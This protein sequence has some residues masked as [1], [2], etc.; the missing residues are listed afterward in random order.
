MGVDIGRI[1]VFTFLAECI[2]FPAVLALGAQVLQEVLLRLA[3]RSRPGVVG[4]GGG[5]LLSSLAVICGVGVLMAK[6]SVFSWVGSYFG[7]DLFSQRFVTPPDGALQQSPQPK[8]LV[9]IYVES[10]E[11]TY[12]DAAVWG[13]DLLQPLHEL[14]GVSFADYRPAAGATWTIAAMVATQCGVPLQVVSQYE[15]KGGGEYNRSFLPGANCL[16]D[17]LQRHGYQNVFLGG[18]PLAFSG[19]GEFLKDHGYEVAYGREEW[20]KEGAGGDA[21][22]EWGLYDDELFARAKVKLARLHA[23][24]RPFNLTMLTLDTH[25]PYGFRSPACRRRG[26]KSF[27]D[28]VECTSH[29]TAEFVRFI[30][31]SGYL[32]DTNVV[33]IGDHL[34][35]SNPVYDALRNIRNRRIFNTFISEP[36]PVKNT[37][38]IVPFDLYPT[39][40][41]FVGFDLMGDR[42]GLGYSGF[43]T[44][45]ATR[46]PDR[47]STL[48]NLPL[49]GS[50]TYDKLWQAPSD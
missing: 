20:Q 34:A 19:K 37:E 47:L 15:F 38:S 33:V 25:N 50:R 44:P 12:G 8:N 21:L 17:V 36:P 43:N 24:G 45:E 5:M 27:E 41:E 1:F 7:E 32:K 26:L 14:G 18:A 48:E 39:L 29:Q 46:P 40:L 28:I 16:G 3:R 22:S 42:I 2:A 11:E 10:L 4:Q 30:R 49:R 23:S 35:V 13:R 6:L 9:L 31:Q